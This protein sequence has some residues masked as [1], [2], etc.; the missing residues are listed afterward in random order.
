MADEL[1]ADSESQ[2]RGSAGPPRTVAETRQPGESPFKLYK[3]GQGTKVRAASAAGAGI[4]AL[5]GAWFVHE[6]LVRLP[7][8]QDLTVR[9]LVPLVLLAA[10]AY[11]IFWFCGRSHGVVD[12]MIATEGEMKKVNWSSKREVFGAT[13][14]VIVTVFMLAILLFLVDLA[15]IAFFSSINVLH[16]IDIRKMFF[17]AGQP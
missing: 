12:F 4:I 1:R 2:D 10:A 3:P 8:G 5:S 11:L 7:F 15:F 6:Q 16:V 17:G 13:R 14:V 9:T